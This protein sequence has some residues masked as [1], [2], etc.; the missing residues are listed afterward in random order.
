M[1]TNTINNDSLSFPGKPKDP[2][3]Y[4]TTIL[5]RVLEFTDFK[6]L[7][8]QLQAIYE[9]DERI[10]FGDG[11]DPTPEPNKELDLTLVLTS[12][13]TTILGE[14]N[15]LTFELEGTSPEDLEVISTWTI[16]GGT[17]LVAE[18]VNLS[19]L[20]EDSTI[21]LEVVAKAE[22]YNDFK[23]TKS[24]EV[25]V[26]DAPLKKI[27]VVVN[28]VEKITTT[29]G[30]NQILDYTLVGTLPED[31]VV[32]TSWTMGE[33]FESTDKSIDLINIPNS[34]ELLLEVLI[35]AE[36][37]E[38]FSYS[39]T[40]EVVVKDKPLLKMDPTITVV[41]ASVNALEGTSEEFSVEVDNSPINS[42]ITHKW[43]LDG[44]DSGNGPKFS[45]VLEVTNTNLKVITNITAE[46]Y[47]PF[48]DTSTMDLTVNPYKDF[49]FDLNILPSNTS[50]IEDEEVELSV[51]V[52]R[53][54]EDANLTYSWIK[55]GKEFATTSKT[56]YTPKLDDTKILVKV[57]ASKDG[58]NQKE[59][60]KSIEVTVEPKPLLQFDFTV[61]ISPKPTKVEVDETVVMVS[62]VDGTPDGTNLEYVWE[63]GSQGSTFEEFEYTGTLGDSDL[64]LRV[65]ASKEGYETKSAEFNHS[66]EVVKSPTQLLKED[67]ELGRFDQ[68]KSTIS[69]MKDIF[70]AD[71][72]SPG[73]VSVNLFSE[74]DPSKTLNEVKDLEV[75]C[76]DKN[77]VL[78]LNNTDGKGVYHFDMTPSTTPGEV[79]IKFRTKYAESNAEVKITFTEV[80]TEE[81]DPA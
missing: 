80:E 39:T 6:D 66:I 71:G 57:T 75:F 18:S 8:E 40:I 42:S 60:S 26:E 51:E 25:I 46:G 3:K 45:T 21:T 11:E 59:V 52:L 38:D 48:E 47:E 49:D 36:G 65:V 77:V 53:I 72:E 81:V 61:D 69:T 78:K 15:E 16:N 29:E 74:S 13:I 10:L 4:S 54:P 9:E 35:S 44:V 30:E 41:P 33:D 1:S 56:S 68:S 14:D 63:L 34:G 19:T 50:F 58:Y 73:F 31:A 2:G 37:Y 23:D 20:T 24:T 67:N 27:E 17:P 32:L 12:S 62:K 79:I 5:G 64:N 55:G 43:V 76:T 7:A 70:P 28:T 22:G